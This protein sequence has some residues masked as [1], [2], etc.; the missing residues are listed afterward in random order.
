MSQDNERSARGRNV[1]DNPVTTAPRDH[2]ESR[3]I[4]VEA[5]LDGERE[6]VLVHNGE[7][8]RLRI[9]ANNK[10]ILTK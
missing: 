1:S 10:L 9:T 2:T 8:Y 6:V 3:R 7:A 4:A 5:I